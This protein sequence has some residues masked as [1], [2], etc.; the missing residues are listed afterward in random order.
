MTVDDIKYLA[1]N[2]WPFWKELVAREVPNKADRRRIMRHVNNAVAALREIIELFGE[3]VGADDKD[4]DFLL[5]RLADD[6][7]LDFLLD[8]L[9]AVA[10]RMGRENELANAHLTLATNDMHDIAR[11]YAAYQRGE[12]HPVNAETTIALE[13]SA[14]RVWQAAPELAALTWAFAR[15]TKEFR[16]AKK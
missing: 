12:L 9:K 8:R 15:A 6:K 5:D 10:E 7:D 4:L 16:A 1:K 3:A 13:D 14:E 2:Y 11:V